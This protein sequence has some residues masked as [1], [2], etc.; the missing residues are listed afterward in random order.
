MAKSLLINTEYIGDWSNPGFEFTCANRTID[1]TI[2]NALSKAL[3]DIVYLVALNSATIKKDRELARQRWDK[4]AS[5]YYLNPNNKEFIAINIPQSEC[6]ID[7][8]D[9]Y[10]ILIDSSRM[11]FVAFFLKENMAQNFRDTNNWQN[12][13]KVEVFSDRDVNDDG[14]FDDT[15]STYAYVVAGVKVGEKWYCEKSNVTYFRASTLEEGRLEYFSNLARWNFFKENSTELN[16]DFWETGLFERV[17]DLR[18][19]PD[20]DEYGESVW[21][22]R[23]LNDRQY[24]GQYVI[25]AN[26]LKRQ[27]KA[28]KEIFERKMSDSVFIPFYVMRQFRDSIKASRDTTMFKKLTLI[29]PED[30]TVVMNPI[31]TISDNGVRTLRFY[32]VCAN[33]SS[34]YE[35]DYFEP[36]TIPRGN[37]H[38]G[39]DIVRL[40][41]QVTDWNFS[42]N[43]LDDKNF[44]T[45][46]VLKTIDGRYQ[47]LKR[48]Q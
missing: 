21:K 9:Q 8:V 32:V 1:C 31:V 47:Y 26:A 7:S 24:V 37:S 5:E 36:A 17:R 35:W 44:W 34:I 27:K 29:Y 46:Y 2:N 33:D 39:S 28:A 25:V 18:Q 38:Y 6:I 16:P 10:Q 15:P 14:F 4:L 40:L 41:A 48:R 11:K 20:W 45:R 22:T 30:R 23:E 12:D 42:Y 3:R 13:N 19:D 43:T